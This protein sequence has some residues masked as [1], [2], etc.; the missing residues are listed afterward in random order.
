MSTLQKLLKNASSFEAL[1]FFPKSRTSQGCTNHANSFE[2]KIKG[3]I[4][5]TLLLI[6]TT[7]KE[8]Q[9]HKRSSS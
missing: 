6:N 9:P 7:F 8:S 4:L 1:K 2:T 3:R 5:E